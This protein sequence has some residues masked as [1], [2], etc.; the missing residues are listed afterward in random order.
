MMMLAN[1][2]FNNLEKT[3]FL[4]FYY[5]KSNKFHMTTFNLTQNTSNSSFCLALIDKLSNNIQVD[6]LCTC[7]SPVIDV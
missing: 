6:I 1:F 2:D 4:S 5:L 7:G 3:S